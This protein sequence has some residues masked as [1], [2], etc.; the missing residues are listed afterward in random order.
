MV[1][2]SSRHEYKLCS[3]AP[4]LSDD[5]KSKKRKRSEED[6]SAE[7]HSSDEK[8]KN[9]K[10]R[11]G[12]AKQ[13]VQGARI[14]LSNPG[15][16]CSPFMLDSSSKEKKK[17]KKG[18]PELAE[19]PSQEN[20]HSSLIDKKRDKRD[21]KKQKNETSESSTPATETEFLSLPST[22]AVALPSDP[23][24]KAFLQKHSITITTDDLSPITPVI[25]FDQLSI[26]DG[27]RSAFAGFK[28]PSP[29]Q[30]CTW[31]F[32]LDGRDVV[33][34]AETGRYTGVYNNVGVA[35]R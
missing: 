10:K 21:K 35:I 6:E 18:E 23:E 34:I 14:E 4:T 17:K 15:G 27:L 8:A 19:D 25:T 13:A 2:L 1:I 5:K 28:E 33:G 24:I 16:S 32:A 9:K 26:P 12:D 22:S 11:N 20:N 30:A 31:P 7:T 3:A 29:I